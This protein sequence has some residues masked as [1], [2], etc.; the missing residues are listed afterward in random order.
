[1]RLCGSLSNTRAR[2][3]EGVKAAGLIVSSNGGVRFAF[4]RAEDLGTLEVGTTSKKFV[5]D[6]KIE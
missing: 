5:H 4:L 2:E 3:V 1:M 6:F